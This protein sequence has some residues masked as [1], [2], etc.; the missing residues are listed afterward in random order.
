[1]LERGTFVLDVVCVLFCC[2]HQVCVLLLHWQALH[3][4]LHALLLLSLIT[5]ANTPIEHTHSTR[6]ALLIRT[7][8]SLAPRLACMI[9]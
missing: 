8:H 4:L 2:S 5:Q 9:E 1:M 7:R 6:I 3:A